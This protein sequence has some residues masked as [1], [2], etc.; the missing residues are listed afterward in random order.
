MT[1]SV[2]QILAELDRLTQTERAELAYVLIQSL[3][4]TEDVNASE[5]WDTEL[6]RRSADILDGTVT[7]KP[8]TELFRELSGNGS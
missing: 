1:K 2:H 6:A 7:G 8:A 3:D 5:S 4:A